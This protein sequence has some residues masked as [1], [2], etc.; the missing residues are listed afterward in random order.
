MAICV[1]GGKCVDQVNNFKC[2]CSDGFTG[3]NCEININ[4][5]AAKSCMN[6]GVCIDKINSYQCICSMGYVGIICEES[7]M[8]V[9]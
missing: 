7:E 6:N 8:M 3:E 1:H 9:V 5:C 4:D 2:E